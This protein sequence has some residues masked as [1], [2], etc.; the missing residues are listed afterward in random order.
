MRKELRCPYCELI[1]SKYVCDTCCKNLET[2]S[3]TLIFGFGSLL[4]SE[5]SY[6]FCSL[7]CL[8]T[9]IDAELKKERTQ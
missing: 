5:E 2:I 4:D 7:E 3:I 8:K 1:K 9:F 6:D